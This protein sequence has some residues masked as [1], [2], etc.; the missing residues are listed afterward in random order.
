[1]DEIFQEYEWHGMDKQGKRLSGT[2]R[3]VGIKS[4]ESELHSHQIDVIRIS[5]VKA[6][7]SLFSRSQI[8]ANDIAFFT[9]YFSTMLSAG[10]PIVKALDVI[11]QD[12]DNKSMQSLILAIRNN[13]ATGKTL[14]DTF[15]QFPQHFSDLYCALVRA[16]ERSGT[17]DK[18]LKRLAAYLEKTEKLK[19]KIKKAMIYPI[20]IISVALIVSLVLLIFVMPQFETMFQSYGVKLPFFTRMMLG[21][22]RFLRSYWPLLLMAIL[23]VFFLSRRLQH[24]YPNLTKLKDKWLLKLYIIGPTL[25]KSIIARF[26]STLAITIDAGLPIVDSIRTMAPIMGNRLYS[27]AVN[28]IC[29][30]LTEG[31]TLSTA[32][33]KTKLFPNM[34]IQMVL[35]GEASG[36]LSEMLNNV[37]DYYEDE[38][39]AVVDNLS[40]LLE[41][42]IIVILGIII[43][44]FVI[45]MYL[46]IFKLGSLF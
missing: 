21:A 46:P 20:A 44:S 1:M 12:A 15:A 18:M 25:K 16:G 2:I 41:P 23:A 35:V 27:D 7:T 30:D 4:A 26:A 43:G 28:D 42:I 37:A 11:A 24:H 17:L 3:A 13:I 45:A 39:N 40:A 29:N 10:M 5:L 19:R 32:M 14:S 31:Q 8:K 33:T 36:A 34:A 9:R 6:R 38:V 22:S